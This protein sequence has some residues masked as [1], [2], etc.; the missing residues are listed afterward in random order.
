MKHHKPNLNHF[1]LC[2]QL[3]DFI[4]QEYLRDLEKPPSKNQDPKKKSPQQQGFMVVDAPWNKVPDTAS[5]DEFPSFGAVVQPKSS[6]AW[7]PRPGKSG[8]SGKR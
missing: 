5:N 2:F 7:G 3:Q 4:D 8:K 1:F 6:H